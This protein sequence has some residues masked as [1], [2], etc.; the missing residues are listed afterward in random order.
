MPKYCLKSWAGD[1]NNCY[2]ES[3]QLSAVRK[4]TRKPLK[5]SANQFRA[6]TIK[7]FPLT[8]SNDNERLSAALDISILSISLRMA[9]D[10]R[11]RRN[12][13]ATAVVRDSGV[14]RDRA[15]YARRV[16]R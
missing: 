9:D 2:T 13:Q 3:A 6:L 7:S 11:I 15:H 4:Y 14:L 1:C 5:L 8:P 16:A 12:G 10:A